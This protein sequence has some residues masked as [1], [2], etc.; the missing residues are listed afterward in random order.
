[1]ALRLFLVGVVASL[2]L[3]LPRVGSPSAGNARSW[4]DTRL[5]SPDRPLLLVHEPTATSAIPIAIAS[6][7]PPP[8]SP[9]IVAAEPMKPTANVATTRPTMTIPATLPVEMTVALPTSTEIDELFADLPAI[10][11]LPIPTR[12]VNVVETRTGCLAMPV[13]PASVFAAEPISSPVVRP[14]D[15]VA[16]TPI[17]VVVEAPKPEDK[18]AVF[19]KVVD[20]MASTF[21]ADLSPMPTPEPKPL[22]ADAAIAAPL[23]VA[24]EEIATA[25]AEEDLQSGLAYELN[26]LS[27]VPPA[28]A[29]AP[30]K[31]PAPEVVAATP[32]DDAWTA[33]RAE[34]LTQAVKLTGEAVN[35]WANLLGQRPSAS[36]SSLQR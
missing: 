34:R 30:V 18:D 13:L 26:R 20:S 22:L 11:S 19:A 8:M 27:E 17:A 2:A 36:S 3:D 14:E 12:A 33:S 4:L 24:A 10:D 23:A 5:T 31:E 35:A 6:V 15:I 28:V 16:P 7:D 29:E 1:M 25:L 32:V 9:P 21:T